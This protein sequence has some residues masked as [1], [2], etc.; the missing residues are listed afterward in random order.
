[1]TEDA[2]LEYDLEGLWAANQPEAVKE[3]DSAQEE[4]I[5]LS[6]DFEWD[7]RPVRKRISGWCRRIAEYVLFTLTAS[8][9]VGVFVSVQCNLAHTVKRWSTRQAHNPGAAAQAHQPKCRPKD[10]AKLPF[11]VA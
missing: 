4:D 3:D 7:E 11:S 2:R 1:M 6:T 5:V 8:M 9:N 10:S